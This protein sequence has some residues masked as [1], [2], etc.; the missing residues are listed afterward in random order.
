M[1]D[2]KTLFTKF[3]IIIFIIIFAGIFMA[4]NGCSFIASNDKAQVSEKVINDKNKMEDSIKEE[5][6]QE[7]GTSDISAEED[8]AEI[9]TLSVDEA[10]EIYKGEP[11]YIFIDARSED[12]YKRGHIKNAINIPVLKIEDKIGELSK[13]KQIIVYCNGSHCSQSFL[14]AE[15]IIKYGFKKVYN[16][17]GGGIFEWEYKGYP[18]IKEE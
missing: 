17:G 3:I 8:S 10:Y 1:M 11:V 15:I 5:P 16:I 13:D 7:D 2:K 6:G 4:F 18:V 9:I 14:V 12:E